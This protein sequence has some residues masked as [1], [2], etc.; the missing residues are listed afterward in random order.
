MSRSYHPEACSAKTKNGKQ[1]LN[2]VRCSHHSCR[3]SACPQLAPHTAHNIELVPER[4]R[5]PYFSR[6]P[7]ELRDRVLQEHARPVERDQDSAPV[8][9]PNPVGT[10]AGSN[11][12]TSHNQ[13][14]ENLPPPQRNQTGARVRHQEEARI[15]RG[16]RRLNDHSQRQDSLSTLQ[17]NQTVAQ[18]GYQEEARILRESSHLNGYNQRQDSLPPPPRNQTVAQVRYQEEARIPRESRRLNRNNQRQNNLLPPE[19]LRLSSISNHQRQ[20]EPGVQVQDPI[21]EHH[22]PIARPSHYANVGVHN[23]PDNSY[24]ANRNRELGPRGRERGGGGI[25]IGGVAREGGRGTGGRTE[26]GARGGACISEAQAFE[27][28]HYSERAS[29]TQP[30]ANS[31]RE[32]PFDLLQDTQADLL[33]HTHYNNSSGLPATNSSGR[34]RTLS[35]SHRPIPSQTLIPV[36][37]GF[38]NSRD[39][40]HHRRWRPEDGLILRQQ[41][42]GSRT[43]GER[44]ATHNYT[45]RRS[46]RG[47][48]QLFANPAPPQLDRSDQGQL[49]IPGLSRRNTSDLLQLSTAARSQ[50]NTNDPPQFG[51]TAPPQPNESIQE[52]P[53][54]STRLPSIKN[55]RIGSYPQRPLRSPTHAI[56]PPQQPTYG[57]R[58]PQESSAPAVTYTPAQWSSGILAPEVMGSQSDEDQDQRGQGQKNQEQEGGPQRSQSQ[59][60]QHQGNQSFA[61]P[62]F[63]SSRANPQQPPLQQQS[64]RASLPASANFSPRL[65]STAA[66][67]LDSDI[68]E[69]ISGMTDHVHLMEPSQ[70][71]GGRHRSQPV[72]SYLSDTSP[73]DSINSYYVRSPGD[74]GPGNDLYDSLL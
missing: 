50:R 45:T 40:Q 17:R 73:N 59:R 5:H 35:L 65:H 74:G 68:A 57:Q 15:S 49:A 11:E 47:D 34:L 41:S 31:H 30:Q 62:S 4:E 52:H 2:S 61:G 63:P 8:G 9:P 37:Q 7:R 51:I 18:V 60:S 13:R 19:G 3:D 20:S 72:P 44:P 43:S 26:G 22:H 1:C 66:R 32:Q 70:P 38:Q 42:G 14:E 39:G 55:Q 21:R 12:S 23:L 27:A 10:W 28:H 36:A 69:M 71:P 53:P 54:P 58:G 33:S 24:G 46:Q 64:G 67:N 48:Q 56:A 25:G 29:E 16:S 6:S